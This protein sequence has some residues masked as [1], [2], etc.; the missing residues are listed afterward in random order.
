MD[1]DT[2]AIM[3]TNP[4]TLGIFESHMKEI[5][6]IV[7]E[8]GGFVYCDG[9]NLNALMGI[10]RF[11]DIG[12][13]LMHLNLHKT[14]ST[15]H[16]GGGPG[17]GP[18][19]VKKDLIPYLPVPQVKHVEGEYRMVYDY[20]KTIGKVKSFYGNFLICVR[21]Y[22]YMLSLGGSGL[23]SVS[24][25]AV[26]NA[27]YL[28]KRLESEYHLPYGTETL[29]E[30][31]FS[32]KKQQENG[33]STLDIAKRLIDYGFHPPTIYFPLVV[34]GALMIEPTETESL[35]SLDSF[36]SAMHAV[37]REAREDPTVLKQAP[38]L[39]KITRV[40][41]VSAARKPVLRWGRSL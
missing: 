33:V 39:A 13:D 35:E 37:S 22:A 32:D 17:S 26:L 7:H 31:V 23:K 5:A 30:C 3:I 24:E 38:H 12:C 6:D 40:D 10:V 41:E 34:H 19:A 11:G 8:K 2:A 18:L 20:P 14:F 1:D 28:R 25:N 16:G 4:N 21:A 15:P 36:V 29:H 27:N 9:A